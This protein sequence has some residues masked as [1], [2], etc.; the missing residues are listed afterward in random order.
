M[1]ARDCLHGSRREPIKVAEPG[2]WVLRMGLIIKRN[3]ASATNYGVIA[4]RTEN[5]VV[6][7][8]KLNGVNPIASGYRVALPRRV[9][10]MKCRACD[11]IERLAI[12]YALVVVGLV[13][14]RNDVVAAETMIDVSSPRNRGLLNGCEIVEINIIGPSGE[15]T[16]LARDRYYDV[17]A[18]AVAV[19][20]GNLHC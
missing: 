12:A 2:I 5:N 16:S 13:R 10:G 17:V 4:W 15:K 3:L 9:T 8:A 1:P 19:L 18:G 6:S 7:S 20:I 11:P 14:K